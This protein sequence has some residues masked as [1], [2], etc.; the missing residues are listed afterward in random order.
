MGKY[1]QAKEVVKDKFWIVERNGAK[2]GRADY[3][4]GIQSVLGGVQRYAVER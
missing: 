4:T 2:C 1:L 3:G